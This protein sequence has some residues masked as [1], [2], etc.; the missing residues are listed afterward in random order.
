M[1]RTGAPQCAWNAAAIDAAAL[2]AP[3]TT[4]GRRC[5]PPS[6]GC[7]HTEGAAAWRPVTNASS[8]SCRGES[9]AG[10]A[11][12]FR[13][14]LLQGR[15]GRQLLAFEELEERAAARRDV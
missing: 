9:S 3:S 15:Y 14:A 5:K 8:S 13:G 12:A 4:A 2:P 10:T 1:P 7:R 11:S 6:A